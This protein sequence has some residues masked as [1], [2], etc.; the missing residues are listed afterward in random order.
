MNEKDKDEQFAATGRAAH[1]QSWPIW[2]LA[3]LDLRRTSRDGSK[4]EEGFSKQIG[5]DARF[6]GG[7]EDHNF[8]SLFLLAMTAGAFLLVTWIVTDS[9]LTAC[10]FSEF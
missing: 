9:T 6:D 10:L 5:K 4:S 1:F 2:Q 3:L 8:G 7:Q